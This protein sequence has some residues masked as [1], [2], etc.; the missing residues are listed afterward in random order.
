MYIYEAAGS[1]EN[2][3]RLNTLS[4]PNWTLLPFHKLDRL[5]Q[6][7]GPGGKG[8]TLVTSGIS[9]RSGWHWVSAHNKTQTEKSALMQFDVAKNALVFA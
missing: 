1:L 2:R 9:I 4:T 6:P 5:K 3:A 8:I 7:D